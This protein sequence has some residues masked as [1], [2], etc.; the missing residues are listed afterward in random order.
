MTLTPSESEQEYFARQELE[1]RRK[2]A[3]EQEAKLQTEERNNLKKLHWMRCPKCGMELVEL[4]FR[5]AKI[6][7]CS[8]CDGIWLDAGELDTVA[9]AEGG[10]FMQSLQ[11]LFKP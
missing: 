10:G 2:V 6:D 7:Q 3:Q 5:G 4:E 9:A 11:K 8:S 1:R